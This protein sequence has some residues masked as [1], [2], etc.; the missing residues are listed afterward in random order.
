LHPRKDVDKAPDKNQGKDLGS[1]RDSSAIVTVRQ[2]NE[3]IN[4]HMYAVGKKVAKDFGKQGVFLGEVVSVEYDSDDAVQKAPFFVVE[5]TDGDK[6]DFNEEEFEYDG[7]ELAFQIALDEEDA[8]EEARNVATSDGEEESDRPP[9]VCFSIFDSPKNLTFRLLLSQ[10][11]R[12]NPEQS[13]QPQRK[14]QRQIQNIQT[15]TVMHCSKR[16][17][18][19]NYNDNVS[20]C[21]TL[22]LSECLFLSRKKGP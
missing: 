5:Y 14:M 22:T 13:L 3:T 19:L 4:K 12:K 21:H 2:D 18:S 8:E 17:H 15:L 11:Q 20:F 16:Y 1:D 10:S 9:K 7:C 6:E